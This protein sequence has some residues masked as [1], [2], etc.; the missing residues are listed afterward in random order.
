[1]ALMNPGNLH[2][3]IDRASGRDV[4]YV[5]SYA[6]YAAE[7]RALNGDA[8]AWGHWLRGGD[9]P[10]RLVISTMGAAPEARKTGVASALLRAAI[11][12]CVDNY[13]EGV[14]S[15]I[16]QELRSLQKIG[17]ATRRYALYGRQLG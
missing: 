10:R 12:H 2:I 16:V 8:T 11:Q 1:M 3:A 5:F 14:L 7:V 13:D 15:I 9:R 17:A 6:D 4:G